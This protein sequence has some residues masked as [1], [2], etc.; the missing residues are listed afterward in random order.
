MSSSAAAALYAAA[1]EETEKTCK[2]A[3]IFSTALP[4]SGGY[5]FHEIMI[6]VSAITAILAIILSLG[7]ASYHLLNFVV[8]SAQ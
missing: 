4:I 5:T 2:L 6:I 1:I 8:C 7:L 3:P